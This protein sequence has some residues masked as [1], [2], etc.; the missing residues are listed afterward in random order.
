MGI[1]T[2]KLHARG[3]MGLQELNTYKYIVRG[4]GQIRN[5]I[6]GREFAGEEI[7]SE[8]LPYSLGGTGDLYASSLLAAVM[9]GKSLHEAVRLAGKFVVDAMRITPQQPNFRARGVCFQSV[10]GDITALMH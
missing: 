6:V 3:P 9:A 2:Q 5:F 7:S 4:D 8:E 10:L 1:S